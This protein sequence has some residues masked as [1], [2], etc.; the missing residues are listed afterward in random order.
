M[1]YVVNLD[2]LNKEDVMSVATSLLYTMRGFPSYSVV[3]EI[4][5]I[6]DYE[7]FLKL[8]KYYGG[9][10]IRIP[11]IEEVNDKLRVLVLYQMKEVLKLPWDECLKKAGYSPEESSS[12]RSSLVHFKKMLETQEI[13]GRVYE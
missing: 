2:R 6:L 4:P 8:I 5:Y 3:S 13:G 1:D 9:M 7:S 12:A 11:T 10:T